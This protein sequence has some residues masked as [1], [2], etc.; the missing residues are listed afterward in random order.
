MNIDAIVVPDSVKPIPP[1]W[2]NDVELDEFG[3]EMGDVIGEGPVLAWS[4]EERKQRYQHALRRLDLNEEMLSSKRITLM[5]KGEL[6]QEK[7]RVKAELKRYDTDWKKQ[8]RAQFLCAASYDS[9]DDLLG[10]RITCKCWGPVHW[11]VPRSRQPGPESAFESQRDSRVC[12]EFAK[13]W[14]RAALFSSRGGPAG[15]I[16]SFE[17][18]KGSTVLVLIEAHEQREDGA[19]DLAARGR[20]GLLAGS[21]FVF[22][23]C[24]ARANSLQQEKGLAACQFAFPTTTSC[25]F[26]V[27]AIRTKL[28]EFQ[29]SDRL[30]NHIG[31]RYGILS[32]VE[33]EEA[34]CKYTGPVNDILPIEKEY[35]MYKNIKDEL[36]KV[37][38]QLRSLRLSPS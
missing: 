12:K 26:L 15:W 16:L 34:T 37:E 35:R 18:T 10:R 20:F 2:V 30:S 29:E 6:G 14:Q 22:F 25:G 23:E 8:H 11:N 17:S 31:S 1:Q 5:S 19:A 13:S 28:K 36:Q 21:R 33:K 9:D 27:G 24:Q 7:K 38:M 4:T 32:S 3:A